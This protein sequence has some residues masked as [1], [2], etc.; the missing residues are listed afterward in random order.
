MQYQVAIVYEE[1]TAEMLR[2]SDMSAERIAMMVGFS[3][4][5]TFWKEFRKK[6]GVT[7]AEYRKGNYN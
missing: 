5:N 1:F 2:T 3:S 4:K 6:Y 7:P